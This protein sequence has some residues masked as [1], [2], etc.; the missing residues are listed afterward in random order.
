MATQRTYTPAPPPPHSR[1]RSTWR[2]VGRRVPSRTR[3]QKAGEGRR[4]EVS[5]QGSKCFNPPPPMCSINSSTL[6]NV[7]RVSRK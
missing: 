5:S 7:A 4:G 1:H 3:A 2:V 6:S